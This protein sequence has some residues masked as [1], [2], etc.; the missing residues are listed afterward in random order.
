M[1]VS[2][3]CT[4]ATLQVWLWEKCEIGIRL[5]YWWLK[6]LYNEKCLQ[7]RKPS[8]GE[9]GFKEFNLTC[10]LGKKKQGQLDLENIQEYR[11]DIMAS[12]VISPQLNISCSTQPAW[13]PANTMLNYCQ[14]PGLHTLQSVI[15]SLNRKPPTHCTLTLH[16]RWSLVKERQITKQDPPHRWKR[17]SP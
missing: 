16:C 10:L 3:R 8:K 5:P 15:P 9:C 14:G 17:G 11:F 7:S 4:A 13:N 12:L 2:L 1:K 6:D